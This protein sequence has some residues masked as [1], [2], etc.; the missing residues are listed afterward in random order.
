MALPKQLLC[1]CLI[2]L[3]TGTVAMGAEPK[4]MTVTK[5]TRSKVD[6]A[7]TIDGRWGTFIN[8]KSYCG[9]GGV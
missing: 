3:F 4:G 7:L 9:T 1:L 8:G 5:V 2:L 6:T